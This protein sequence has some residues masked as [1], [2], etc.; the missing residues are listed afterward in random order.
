MAGEGIIGEAFVKIAPDTSGFQEL[1]V[2][3]V[4]RALGALSRE[5]QAELPIQPRVPQALITDA[6]NNAL[7]NVRWDEAAKRFRTAIGNQFTSIDRE[8][9]KSLETSLRQFRP[10]ASV[11][12]PGVPNFSSIA[13][14]GAEAFRGAFGGVASKF[15]SQMDEAGV[16][17]ATEIGD[18]AKLS[19]KGAAESFGAALRSAS[20][21]L[22]SVAAGISRGIRGGAGAITGALSG[23]M[24]SAGL[25]A[26]LVGGLVITDVMRKVLA[27]FSAGSALEG[28]RATLTALTGSVDVANLSIQTLQ[29]TSAATGQAMQP[30]LDAAKQLTAVGIGTGQAVQALSAVAQYITVFTHGTS[31]SVTQIQRATLALQEMGTQG[32]VQAKFLRQL[33]NDGVP[34]YKILVTAAKNAGISLTGQDAAFL[35]VSKAQDRVTKATLALQ[36]ASQ[37]QATALAKSGAASAQYAN[38]T[39]A[40]ESAQLSLSE[41]GVALSAAMDKADNSHGN[42]MAALRAGKITTQEFLDALSA[43]EN[44]QPV[45]TALGAL[46]DN[47]VLSLNKL[48]ASIAIGAAQLFEPIQKPLANAVSGL[49]KPIQDLVGAGL[50]ENTPLGKLGQQIAAV[51]PVDSIQRMADAI[52]RAVT[53]LSKAADSGAVSKFMDKLKELEPVIGAVVGVFAALALSFGA[54]LPLIGGLFIPLNPLLGLFAGLAITIPGVRK[55]FEELAVGVADGVRRLGN[56]L[57]PL[58]E[59]IENWLTRIAD[60]AKPVARALGVDLVGGVEAARPFLRSL[61]DLLGRAAL[62]VEKTLLVAFQQLERS[63]LGDTLNSLIGL[64]TRLGDAFNRLAPIL[65]TLVTQTLID[66]VRDLT[67]LAEGA[68]RLVDEFSR[69][70]QPSKQLNDNLGALAKGLAGGALA[71]L[72]WQVLGPVVDSLWGMGKAI[73]AVLGAVGLATGG[74]ALAVA[75]AVMLGLGVAAAVLVTHWQDVVSLAGQV[76]SAIS[77]VWKFLNADLVTSQFLPAWNDL[78]AGF[79]ALWKALGPLQPAVKLLGELLAAIVILAVLSSLGALIGLMYGLAAAATAAAWF[80]KLLVGGV[81]TELIPAIKI[82]VGD[83]GQIY[84]AI[85]D[86]FQWAWN[87][88]FGSSIVPD[89]VHGFERWFGSLPGKVKDWFNAVSDNVI[90]ELRTLAINVVPESIKIGQNIGAGILSGIRQGLGPAGLGALGLAGGGVAGAAAGAAVGSGLNLDLGHDI[91][92]GKQA[93]SSAGRGAVHV[94]INVLGTNAS[95]DDIASALSWRLSRMGVTA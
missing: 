84:H 82:L 32:Y 57:S 52:G 78:V 7:G 41:A 49:V 54:G 91:A 53:A 33:V 26:G 23:V 60:A 89:I 12:L 9:A 21:S 79:E 87:I 69:T 51:I 70:L 8:L 40:V 86:P 67:G 5:A 92:L 93:L 88:L 68:G 59:P 10:Q 2:Q 13:L 62:I 95:P 61:I 25:A 39:R 20:S 36:T 73:A 43:P 24:Q 37:N 90:A 83:F 34:A 18:K 1:L 94:T 76:A 80:V 46:T 42:L 15:G 72:G 63:G 48:K 19:L 77:D 74:E 17:A 56:A 3:G 65:G 85:V 31:S 47:L 45:T 14:A 64:T 29:R 4:R 35:D 50:G 27:G 58:L 28:S 22:D 71:L 38:A 66:F 30:L 16:A 44:L 11:A 6:V 55:D 75:L 81:N